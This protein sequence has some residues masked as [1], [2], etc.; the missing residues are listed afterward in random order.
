MP[1]EHRARCSLGQVTGPDARSLGL[2]L[3]CSVV[4]DS[5]RP[6]GLDP[7]RFLCPWDSP[8]KSTRVGCH[9]L[10]QGIFLTRGWKLHLLHCIL[11]SLGYLGSPQV[12]VKPAQTSQ[13]P[14]PGSQGWGLGPRKEGRT[15][16]SPEGGGQLKSG[17]M[18][19]GLNHS[20]AADKP[21]S[22]TC[23]LPSPCWSCG[24]IGTLLGSQ[25]CVGNR[26]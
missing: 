2:V 10:L 12:S 23:Y 4:S 17:A 16:S 8:G 1:L 5:L 20:L 21:G 15:V 24:V 22:L 6:H 26:Q 13:R 11:Y 18:Q 19:C 3:S 7:A 9:S 14:K 25:G